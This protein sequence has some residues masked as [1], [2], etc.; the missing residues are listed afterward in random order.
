MDFL[1]LIR[2][3]PKAEV[4]GLNP[5]VLTNSRQ[6]LEEIHVMVAV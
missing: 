3:D 4:T 2:S 5:V 1:A 6:E